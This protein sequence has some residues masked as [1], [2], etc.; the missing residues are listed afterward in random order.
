MH[1]TDIEKNG[2]RIYNINNW[3]WG[4]STATKVEHTGKVSRYITKELYDV[5]VGRMQ[6]K[7]CPIAGQKITYVEM[8]YYGELMKSIQ[9]KDFEKQL[10]KLAKENKKTKKIVAKQ[11]EQ[12]DK[13]IMKQAKKPYKEPKKILTMERV[14]FFY[15][16]VIVI[17]LVVFKI[18]L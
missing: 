11:K 15:A 8:D 1:K 4:F 17:L 9:R 12:L 10:K 3:K 5:I 7:K 18:R 6:S 2:K 16:V 13:K 14:F